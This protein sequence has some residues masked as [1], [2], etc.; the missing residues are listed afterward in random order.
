[1]SQINPKQR[2]IGGQ[3]NVTVEPSRRVGGGRTGV[4]VAVNDHYAL[5]DVDPR[6]A[7]R[8]MDLLE[9]NF[10]TSLDRSEAMIDHVM[11]LVPNREL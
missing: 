10:K 7:E 5:G 4:Y 8:C 1:M 6:A 9:K 11:S 2:P 3:I